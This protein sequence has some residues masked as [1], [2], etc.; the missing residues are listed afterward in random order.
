M[1]LAFSQSQ[2]FRIFF[3]MF[4][5]IVI[6]AISHGFLLIPALLA[7][8]PFIYSESEEAA[9][10]HGPDTFQKQLS[11]RVHL[12]IEQFAAEDNDDDDVAANTEA[13]A[14]TNTDAIR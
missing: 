5:G 7:E 11:K 3:L 2:A 9:K 8:M 14:E 13:N 10:K 12:S 4:C 6:I 1:T